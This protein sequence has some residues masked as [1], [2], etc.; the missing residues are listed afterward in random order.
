MSEIQ[1]RSCG[2]LILRTV[3]DSTEQFLL[4]KH[5]KRWDLPKGH[6]DPGE[7]EMECALREL[8]EETGI[9]ECH[10]QVDPEFVFK[11]QY[12]V[13]YKRNGGKPQLKELV[14]FLATLTEEVEIQCTEHPG[15]QWWDWNPPHKIQDETIDP[16]L[17]YLEDFRGSLL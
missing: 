5:P 16:L 3:D 2:F 14:V 7:T 13:R 1:L 4:M 6:V 17:K 11:Q 12:T 8:W 10:I 9:K 15:Y